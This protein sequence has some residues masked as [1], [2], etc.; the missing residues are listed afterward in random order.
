MAKAKVRVDS[1]SIIK[2][3]LP[4]PFL[5]ASAYARFLRLE[6][7]TNDSLQYKI[8]DRCRLYEYFSSILFSMYH[9]VLGVVYKICRGNDVSSFAFIYFMANRILLSFS[10]SLYTGNGASL[11]LFAAMTF[12]TRLPRIPPPS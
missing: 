6:D 12:L 3:M 5:R 10:P 1:E 2:T 7:R 11:S 9:M 8:L 4:R